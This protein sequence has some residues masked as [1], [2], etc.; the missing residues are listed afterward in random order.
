[1]SEMKVNPTDIKE[2]LLKLAEAFHKLSD[3][4]VIAENAPVQAPMQQP[5][6]PPQQMSQYTAPN[7]AQP[8]A[9]PV[10]QNFATSPTPLFRCRFLCHRLQF[11]SRQHRSRVL[12]RQQQWRRNTHRI[13]WRLPVP[14]W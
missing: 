5:V 2:G 4:V 12:F 8:Q 11:L 13:N 7:F 6:L 1:M 9:V 10:Q 14:V 3:A